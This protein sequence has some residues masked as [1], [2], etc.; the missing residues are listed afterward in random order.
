VALRTASRVPRYRTSHESLELQVSLWNQTTA[1]GKTHSLTDLS[2]INIIYIGSQAL[3]S[4]VFISICHRQQG[5]YLDSQITVI[6][7]S[8]F[9]GGMVLAF[10]QTDMLTLLYLISFALDTMKYSLCGTF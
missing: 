9:A 8:W 7:K 1:D 6:Y 2:K 4:S 3:A 10:H 5:T